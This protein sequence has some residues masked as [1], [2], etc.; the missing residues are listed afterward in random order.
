[1][2]SVAYLITPIYRKGNLNQDI[3]EG[4]IKDMIYCTE[5]SV[6]RSE[7]FEA[8]RSGFNPQ[9]VITTPAINYSGQPECEYNGV[10]FSVYRTYYKKEADEIELYLEIKAGVTH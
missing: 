4:E 8:G 7:F 2:E 3:R 10:R 9:T 1:M 6:S 5:E